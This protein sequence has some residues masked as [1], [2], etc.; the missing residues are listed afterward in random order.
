MT[1]AMWQVTVARMQGE[2]ARRGVA[3]LTE[4]EQALL[5]RYLAA[6]SSGQESR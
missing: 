4:S 5:L 6:H 1:T 2:L 3:P